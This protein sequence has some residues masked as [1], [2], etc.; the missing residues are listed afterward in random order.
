MFWQA[1][2]EYLFNSQYNYIGYSNLKHSRCFFFYFDF[3]YIT[4]E[5]ILEYIQIRFKCTNEKLDTID[6]FIM[7]DEDDDVSVMM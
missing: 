7:I 2:Y 1:I 3:Q 4:F 5:Q 6:S